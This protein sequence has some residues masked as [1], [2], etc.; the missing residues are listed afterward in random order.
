MQRGVHALLA[1]PAR[2]WKCTNGDEVQIIAAGLIN[3]HEG[4][5]FL[6][7]AVLHG[8]TVHVGD[9]E[10][11]V[12]AA[13]WIDHDHHNDTRYASLLVHAVIVDDGPPITACRWTIILDEAEVLKRMRQV[14]RRDT[15]SDVAVEELQHFALLRL[16]RQTA[17]ADS[18]IRRLG[19][20]GAIQGMTD[21]FIDRLIKKRRRPRDENDLTAIRERITDSE[22]GMFVQKFS[23][24][25][26]DEILQQL[27]RCER[28]PIASEGPALRREIIINAILPILCVIATEQ[29]HIVLLQWYWSARAIHPYGILRRRYPNQLQDHVWQQ[30]GMLEH[31]RQHGRR[32]S[33]CGEVIRSYGIDHTVTFLSALPDSQRHPP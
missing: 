24:V 11:H 19:V 26:D 15:R 17:E 16:L 20:K 23:S 12:Q 7:A 30:Q 2:I 9:I 6:D 14:Q 29:Q 10:F 28:S 32:I 31:F 21:Q 3:V 1:D 13:E 4:P 27:V 22:I 5:D 8:G 18:L 25:F 33:S